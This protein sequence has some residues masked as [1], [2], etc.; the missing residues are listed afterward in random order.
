[1]RFPVLFALSA[2]LFAVDLL[3][4]DVIPFADELLLGLATAIFATWKKRR[5]EATLAREAA[6]GPTPP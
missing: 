1:M 6:P 3:V 2:V 5:H 4:P